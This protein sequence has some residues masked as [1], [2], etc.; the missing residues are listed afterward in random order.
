MPPSNGSRPHSCI[1]PP[2]GTPDDRLTAPVERTSAK[3]DPT[4][5]DPD[6]LPPE[7]M[8][9]EGLDP[10]LD[11]VMGVDTSALFKAANAEGF[12]TIF[13]G[14]TLQGWEEMPAGKEKAWTVVDGG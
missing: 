10:S 9:P 12:V 6:A 13:D 3:P 1:W 2:P 14:K 8:A 7:G 5:E 11:P 4:N